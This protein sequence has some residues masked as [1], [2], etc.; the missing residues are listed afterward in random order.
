[1]RGRARSIR[2]AIGMVALMVGCGQQPE[3]SG[4]APLAEA[5]RALTSG[6]DFVVTAVSAPPSARPGQ[7]FNTAVTVCNQGSVGGS[8][9]VGLYLSPDAVITVPH[10]PGPTTDQF[11]EDMPTGPLEPGQCRTLS[12]W[13]APQ[14]Y[15]E[16]AYYLGAVVD[17]RGYTPE[18]NESNNTR[19]ARIGFGDRADFIVSAV[20]G[21]PSARPGQP[22]TASVTVCNQGLRADGT[23]VELYLSSDTVITSH[24]SSP[25]PDTF[26]EGGTLYLQPGQCQ[27]L[28]LTGPASVH[29]EG[30]YYLGAVVDS[31]NHRVELI[32]DNNTRA[33]TR[34]GVG[35]R[36]DFTVTSV[37][38]P[39]SAKPGQPL[40]ASVT[41][42]NQ[43][44]YGDSA[45]VELYLS[46]DKIITPPSSDPRVGGVPTDHLA[47]GQCQTVS[48]SGS[49]SAP[50]GAYYLGAAVDPYN[51]RLEL[52]DDNNT[53]VGTRIGVGN[54][55][56]FVVSSVTGPTS[57]RPGQAL[58]ASVAVCNQGTAPGGTHVALY[59]S[60][61]AV[62]AVPQS[63]SS[64]S[65]R[66]LEVGTTSTLVPGQCQTL[67]LA[68]SASVPEEGPYYLGAVV[69]PGE[70]APELIEDNNSRAGTRLGIGHRPD[71]TVTSVTGPASAQ[72]GQPIT[73]NV[74]V[75]NQGTQGDGTR[76]E[77]Y[78]SADKV[79]TV[80]E[81]P[82]PYTDQPL[83]GVSTPY[84]HP[85][86]CETLSVQGAPRLPAEGPYYLGAVVDPS[87]SRPELIEDNNARVGT[88]IGLGAKAD[89][90]ISAVT[91]P[92]SAHAGQPITASVTV[93]NQGTV[94][95]GTDVELYLSSD[96]VITVPEAPS[97]YTD[98]PLVRMP[99]Q[100]LQPGQCQ[101]LSM[102]GSASV[103]AEGPYYLGAVADPY[104]R[105][106]EL[107]KDNNSRAGTRL[108]IGSGADFIVTSVTGP[109]SAQAGQPITA[110]VTVCNQGTQ[111]DGARVELYLSPN[112]VITPPAAS[113]SSTDT[114]VAGAPTVYLQPG[115]CQ[116]LSMTGPASVPAEGPYYLGAA[117]DPTDSRPELIEDNNTRV[118]SARIGIG[119]RADF[120][121]TSVTGPASVQPGQSFTATVTVCNQGTRGDSTVVA[122]FLSADRVITVPESPGDP[123]VDPLVATGSTPV[124]NPGQCLAVPLTGTASVLYPG[125]YY[126][127]GAADP[128]ESRLE[129]IEDNNTRAGNL[130]SIP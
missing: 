124:L 112:S 106:A 85:G 97:P 111:G 36:P 103:P 18:A 89:F 72:M 53:R 74:T 37:T 54:R 102:T 116:T 34:I 77:L 96:A 71:F 21:P 48:V 105:R 108:G 121:I 51:N 98:R 91:G 92:V 45:L 56:D 99:S 32:E 46:A 43:G 19:T 128:G 63:S 31:F 13:S 109:A 126:L 25:T 129:L 118:S 11:L 38:G 12:M 44:T 90:I 49:A 35:N 75:C 20:S 83:A 64:Y 123:N 60:S 100:L 67:S 80:A 86:Q 14:V 58:K 87:E 6:L 16:G 88:R 47:P 5:P 62:I 68:G 4:E 8:T 76:V 81:G 122:L 50:E 7:A 110:S 84:L 57:A 15:S 41:V 1:M 66:L 79:V 22:I 93:C 104:E 17:P 52:I 117:V 29:S 69:D 130:I 55:P 127:G 73:V 94:A 26:I 42:C 115:Q 78:V 70:S 30:A 10:P 59:L 28:E 24:A 119:L 39:T 101:T 27:A 82:S 95:D 107:I 113:A 40:T 23:E 9:E 3:G 33:G 125:P 61:D 120:I 114:F 65:D 2:V